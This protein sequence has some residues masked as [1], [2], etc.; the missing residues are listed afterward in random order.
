MTTLRLFT[1]QAD[2]ETGEWIGQ[3][4]QIGAVDRLEWLATK[5]TDEKHFD[6]FERFSEAHPDGETCAVLVTWA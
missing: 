4:E 1:V 5:D 3:A 6:I 2:R